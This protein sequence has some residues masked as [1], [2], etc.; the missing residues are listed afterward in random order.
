MDFAM[1]TSVALHCESWSLIDDVGKIDD[2]VITIVITCIIN[3]LFILPALI[4][5]GIIIIAIIKTP[6]LRNPSNWL[7]SNLIFT[8]FLMGFLGQPLYIV[9]N[10]WRVQGVLYEHCPTGIAE[11]IFT[12][13]L[14]LSLMLTLSVSSLDRYLAI[15]L[16][17]Q[18]RTTMTSF[19]AIIIIVTLWV[20]AMLCGLSLFFMGQKGFVI[21]LAIIFM[22]CLLVTF[23]AYFKAFHGLRKHQTQVS[24]PDNVSTVCINVKKYHRSFTTMLCVFLLQLL[25]YTPDICAKFFSVDQTT[26]KSS[27]IATLVSDT[28]MYA[29]ATLNPLFFLWRMRDVRRA[30]KNLYKKIFRK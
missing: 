19:R 16:M 23:V 22:I 14:P 11:R 4:L 26:P 20:F 2:F 27:L 6:S 9:I 3:G 5:N 7:L 8:D 13:I 18:Y 24:S 21:L 29:N 15:R 28:I 1:N 12:N 17:L 30:C 25:F 10:I